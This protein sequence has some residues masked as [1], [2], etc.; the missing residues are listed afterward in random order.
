M[1]KAKLVKLGEEVLTEIDLEM[2][3][4]VR[5]ELEKKLCKKLSRVF[6]GA[7]KYLESPRVYPK[8]M[9]HNEDGIFADYKSVMPILNDV[10]DNA[11][12]KIKKMRTTH[13]H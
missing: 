9:I 13:D 5:I 1:N 11:L 2:E 6:S 8:P 10:F 4:V 7:A 12:N 3:T